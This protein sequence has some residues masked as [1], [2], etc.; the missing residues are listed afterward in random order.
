MKKGITDLE[1][2]RIQLAERMGW[3][4]VDGMRHDGEHVDLWKS[5]EGGDAMETLEFYPLVN[6]S[7]DYKVLE[8]MRD[9]VRIKHPLTWQTF[10]SYISGRMFD[11]R[12]G[13]FARAAILAIG[14]KDSDDE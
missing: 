8:W 7:D 6:P 2:L 4:M 1:D 5:P 13:D 12:V 9:V 10:T 14:V 11:Y 3:Q